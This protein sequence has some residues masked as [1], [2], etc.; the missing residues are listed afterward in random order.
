[1]QTEVIKTPSLNVTIQTESF[2]KNTISVKM[3][4]KI[5]NFKDRAIDA[6]EPI[7]P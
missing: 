7:K 3:Q 1:M 5:I 4:T 6:T 2:S